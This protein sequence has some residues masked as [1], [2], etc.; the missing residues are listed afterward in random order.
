MVPD[1]SGIWLFHC[2]VSFH[3]LLGMVNR[4]VVLPRFCSCAHPITDSK[5]TLLRVGFG[6]YETDET[7]SVRF[8]FGIIIQWALLIRF[9]NFGF[10]AA[11]RT[12]NND[13]FMTLRDF[14]SQPF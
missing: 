7:D 11:I 1:D 12:E 2:H 6:D 10:S 13:T 8:F 9:E 3:H 14:R 5:E 4:Y